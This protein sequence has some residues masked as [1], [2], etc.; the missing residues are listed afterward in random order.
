MVYEQGSYFISDSSNHGAGIQNE[1]IVLA[2]LTVIFMILT[3]LL[4][5]YRAKRINA[6][7]AVFYTWIEEH[8]LA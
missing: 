1:L 5:W 6:G 8:G 4:F 3:V 2:V 7:E